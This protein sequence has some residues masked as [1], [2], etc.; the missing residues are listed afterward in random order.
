[1]FE[2]A[3]KRILFDFEVIL[4]IAMVVGLALHAMAGSFRRAPAG[5]IGASF[6]PIDLL[7]MLFP[8]ALFLINPVLVFVTSS[9]GD[10]QPAAELSVADQLLGGLSQVVYFTFIGIMTVA[11][12]RWVTMRSLTEMLGLNR[13]SIGWIIIVSACATFLSIALCGILVGNLSTE[14]LTSIFGELDAQKPVEDLKNAES[15]PV[16]ALSVLL[17]CFCAPIVEEL[18]FR[19]YFYGV[20][21]R[22][23]SPLFAALISSGLFAVVHLNL[24]AFLPLWLFAIILTL[25]YELTRCIWVPILI[26]AIFN[27]VNVLLL[28]EVTLW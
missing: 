26:H 4:L 17:A 8:L 25:S 21:K 14:Y 18:L 16:I 15:A 24:P 5:G 19:G 28:F 10:T 2:F 7:L 3:A 23:S 12:M 20:L 9:G 6:H 27:G 13:M 1:M 11:I 22:F